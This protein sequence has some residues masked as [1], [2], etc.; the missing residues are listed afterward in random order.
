[1]LSKTQRKNKRSNSAFN[2][3]DIS[4]TELI[5]SFNDAIRLEFPHRRLIDP[6]NR[7]L[8]DTINRIDLDFVE[9]PRNNRK[10][11]LK[12]Y[13]SISV[14]THLSDGWE[15]YSKA[16]QSSIEGNSG[17]AMHLAY[18]AELRSVM[19]LM[20][21]QGLGIFNDI[22]FWVNTTGN[23]LYKQSPNLKTHKATETF[24]QDWASQTNNSSGL[25]DSLFVSN[26]SATNWIRHSGS[27]S[28]A[29]YL[30]TQL[31]DWMKAWSIDLKLTEDQNQRN[32]RS[33]RPNY[34]ITNFDSKSKFEFLEKLWNAC[35]PD[36]YGTFSEMDRHILRNLLLI[37]FKFSK[38]KKL[39]GDT[40]SRQLIEDIYNA[41]GMTKDPHLISFL[42]YQ[43]DTNPY[44]LFEQAKIKAYNDGTSWNEIPI[45]CRALLL[46][47][48]A[49]SYT[50]NFINQTSIATSKSSSLEFWWNAIAVNHGIMKPTDRL[51]TI[52]DLYTEVSDLLDD[53]RSDG[54]FAWICQKEVRESFAH[55][56]QFITQFERPMFWGLGL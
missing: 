18:Y 54:S 35:A 29:T 1:M 17:I 10:N 38:G 20:A 46:M 42:S 16:V 43:S 3:S 21:S 11:Q 34:L 15:Y 30:G 55:N 40:R 33:Y 24:I 2:I 4:D 48:I 14:L 39:N 32:D 19:A 50:S 44:W 51:A 13:I 49:T 36:H 41:E 37:C 22:H 27:S 47:R 45:L 28:H 53:I 26:L 6:S 12:S 56:Y 7:Y 23:L 52:E 5:K 8:S 9:R 31:K 25:F